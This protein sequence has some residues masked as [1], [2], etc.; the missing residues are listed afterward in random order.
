M[1]RLGRNRQHHHLAAEYLKRSVGGMDVVH[2][3]YKSG[4]PERTAKFIKDEIAKWAPI[5]VRIA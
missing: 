1:P 2:V 5:N 4:A 3:P